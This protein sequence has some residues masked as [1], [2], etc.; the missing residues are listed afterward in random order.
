LTTATGASAF[1]LFPIAATQAFLTSGK[2]LFKTAPNED[3]AKHKKIVLFRFYIQ[4]K[5][6]S[7]EKQ[8][9]RKQE[10][11]HQ[12]KESQSF[13]NRTPPVK[14]VDKSTGFLSQVVFSFKL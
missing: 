8:R 3:E 11:A 9:K 6:S 12:T 1:L 2:A 7:F 5:N 10:K 14:I 13:L 4:Q